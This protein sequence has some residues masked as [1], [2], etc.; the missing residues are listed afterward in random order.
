[1]ALP[2]RGNMFS[3]RSTEGDA[4]A[5]GLLTPSIPC[6]D[7]TAAV[8]WLC[9]VLGFHPAQVFRIPGGGVAFAELHFGGSAV[10][11]AAPPPDDNPW[12]RSVHLAQCASAGAPVRHVW[13]G[14]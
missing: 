13:A 8:E 11:V 5:K 14:V 2:E 4:M 3:G 12:D 7:A 1:M 6:Q 9:E 10:F